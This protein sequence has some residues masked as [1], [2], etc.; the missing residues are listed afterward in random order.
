MSGKGSSPRPF[1]VDQET[2]ESNWEKAFGKKD[3]TIKLECGECS[4][5]GTIDEALLDE[6]ILN[7]ECPSC[8]TKI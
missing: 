2:F 8:G 6:D 3:K 4:W 1:S 7:Y 5:Q